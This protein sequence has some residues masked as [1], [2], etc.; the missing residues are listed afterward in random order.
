MEDVQNRRKKT[1]TK[2]CSSHSGVEMPPATFIYTLSFFTAK[3]VLHSFS[4]YLMPNLSKELPTFNNNVHTLFS[5]LLLFL[6]LCSFLLTH[7][8]YQERGNSFSKQLIS[9]PAH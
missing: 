5:P 3:E 2:R 4:H 6:N 1:W 8:L 7:G 9:N